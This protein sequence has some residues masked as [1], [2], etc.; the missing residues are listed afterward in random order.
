[1]LADMPT[2]QPVLTAEEVRAILWIIGSG[3]LSALTAFIGLVHVGAKMAHQP[4]SHAKLF[5]PL[6]FHVAVPCLTVGMVISAV[7]VLGIAH[8]LKG[9]EIVG[10]VSSIVGFTLG[11]GA[12]K[13]ARRGPQPNRQ[14]KGSV[15]GRGPDDGP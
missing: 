4:P 10:L 1:M 3:T 6:L 13:F 9:G 7:T 15:R 12:T 2:T 11:V 5:F 8:V 14:P